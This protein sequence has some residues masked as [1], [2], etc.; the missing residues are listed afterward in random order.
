VT[1][2]ALD[3]GMLLTMGAP[4]A[5]DRDRAGW[6]GAGAVAAALVTACEHIEAG[7]RLPAAA[8]LDRTVASE[9]IRLGA[10][11]ATAS[12]LRVAVEAV[13]PP[14]QEAGP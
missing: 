14:T 5:G 3:A 12:A 4:A 10:T 1:G 13:R 2:D 7:D 9:R 8:D 6:A 11:G